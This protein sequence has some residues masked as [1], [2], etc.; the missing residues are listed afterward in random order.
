M[1]LTLLMKNILLGDIP[2]AVGLMLFGIL[3]IAI[4]IGLRWFLESNEKEI[5]GHENLRK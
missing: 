2:E 1:T 4:T 3:L 5:E